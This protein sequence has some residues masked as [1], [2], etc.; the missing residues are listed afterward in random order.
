MVYFYLPHRI[1]KVTLFLPQAQ[2]LNISSQFVMLKD[3]QSNHSH[4][5]IFMDNLN[6][7]SYYLLSI[8]YIIALMHKLYTNFGE[9]FIMTFI[10]ICLFYY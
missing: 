7:Y 5:F 4:N 2:I 9:Y 6:T 10:Y 8:C 3:L 1:Y